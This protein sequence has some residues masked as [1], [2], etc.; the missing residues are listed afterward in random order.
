VRRRRSV[1][2]PT[3]CAA[4]SESRR[5][6]DCCLASRLVTRTRRRPRTPRASDAQALT[7]PSAFTAENVGSD[8]RRALDG[9]VRRRRLKPPL[10]ECSS[11]ARNRHAAAKF[12]RR[13][14]RPRPE[15]GGHAPRDYGARS[16]IWNRATV[17]LHGAVPA[18]EAD[19]NNCI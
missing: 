17:A 7:T 3:S 5:V 4:T 1:S 16:T 11:L 8:D 13:C 18:P 15:G 14:V 12:S 10:R 9:S 19:A 6:T 2:S